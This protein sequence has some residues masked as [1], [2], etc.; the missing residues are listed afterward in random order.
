MKAQVRGFV[1]LFG[2]GGVPRVWSIELYPLHGYTRYDAPRSPY[3]A[4]VVAWGGVAA[5]GAIAL[6][7]ILYTVFFGFTSIGP[8]NAIL[9]VFGY[10]SVVIAIHNL[11]PVG[12]LDGAT[13]WRL[14]PHLWRRWWFA[15]RRA[16]PLSGNERGGEGSKGGWVP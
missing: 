3:D 11:I 6:P 4:C 10:L 14:L 16:D 5:Q 2:I 15:R 8:L 13:A 7:L 12:R 1:R 9:A